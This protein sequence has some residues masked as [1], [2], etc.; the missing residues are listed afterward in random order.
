M[1]RVVPASMTAAWKDSVKVGDLKPTVRATIQIQ[2][3][4]GFSYDTAYM[5]GGSFSSSTD[6]HAGTYTSMIFGD[7]NYPREIRNIQSCTWQRSADQDVATCTITLLNSEVTP[8]GNSAEDSAADDFEQSGAFTYNR[9]ST[10]LGPG[11][12]SSNPWGYET[13]LGWNG[14]FVPDRLIKTYEG[15]GADYS[16]AACDDPHLVQTGTWL[17]DSVDYTADGVITLTCRDLGRLLL[18]Q[19]C[20][21]P[22]I[23]FAQYPLSWV[24][25]QS[26]QVRARDCFGGSWQ[27]RLGRF[28]RATSSNRLY[29]GRGLVDPPYPYYTSSTGTWNGHTEADA[30]R[31]GDGEYWV[32]TGQDTRNSFVWWQFDLTKA[33]SIAAIRLKCA[34]G[35]YV[36]YISVHNGTKWLGTKNIPYKV[37]TAGV[38]NGSGIRYMKATILDRST[39][40]AATQE[41]MLPRKVRTAKKIRITF[42]RLAHNGVGTRPWRAALRDMQI[43]T[44][45]WSR[46]GYHRGNVLKVVGNYADYTDIVQIAC[47][48]A[49]FYWPMA[50]TG[51]SYMRRRP[52]PGAVDTIQHPVPS[53]QLTE[54]RVWGEF[55]ATYTAGLADLT[56]DT[57][58]KKPLMDMIN[59]VRDVTGFRFFVDE[60]GRAVWRMPN[61]WSL[62][63]FVTGQSATSYHN[64]VS[65]GRTSEIV[66]LDERETLLDYGTQ[67]SSANIRERIFVANVTGKIGSLIEGFNPYPVGMRRITGWTDQHFGSKAETRVM[68]DF[69][70]AQQMFSWKKG[71]ATIPGYP[72]I[73]V[74]DQIRIYERVTNETFYHYVLG[75]ESSLD[76]NT[77]EYTYKLNTHWL[78]ENPS[79]A[80]VVR[81][82]ELSAGTKAYLNLL[83][84]N[85][86]NYG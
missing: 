24:K 20:F 40:T 32:S 76:M 21:P 80:W 12:L 4:R 79:D 61:L 52:Y 18:D 2:R 44:G 11:I 41:I 9:G 84:F 86:V 54:G 71:Q 36:A 50:S 83:N 31:N 33:K 13:D 65:W 28:G 85:T 67:L 60:M 47:A 75:V 43:Y 19:I 5:T 63:N 68:A 59:Y 10:R 77:G 15:Y 69:I 49:G 42:T 14:M 73:Q 81:V 70:S 23:P 1:S 35:P 25:V 29:Y 56:V 6:H 26:R 48:W 58:D 16:K 74:D 46:L 8:I 62:G 45:S 3:Q 17:I 78:G 82:N 53:L 57:F 22:I 30:L 39:S 34:M 64:R 72:K 27:G 38:N 7:A 55:Q 51:A 66:T 37:T